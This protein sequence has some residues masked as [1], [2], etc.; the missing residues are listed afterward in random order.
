MLGRDV[1]VRARD[2]SLEMAP[3]TLKRVHMM[4]TAYILLVAM[5]DGAVRVG[6]SL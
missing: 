6:P 3:V 2:G 1:D 5:I 4:D